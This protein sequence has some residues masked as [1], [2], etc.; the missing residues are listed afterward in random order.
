MMFKVPFFAPRNNLQIF[1]EFFLVNFS[2]LAKGQQ[3]RNPLLLDHG[4][5]SYVRQQD[6]DFSEWTINAQRNQCD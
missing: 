1:D 4:K 3:I 2:N 5:W 6:S